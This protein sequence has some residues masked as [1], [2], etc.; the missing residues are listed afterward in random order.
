MMDY[1]CTN[2]VIILSA[3]LVFIV[4]TDKITEDTNHFTPVT[5]VDMS[6]NVKIIG[7]MDK[8]MAM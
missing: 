4:R 3:V 1:P 5:T 2:L 7:F 6:N 8:C